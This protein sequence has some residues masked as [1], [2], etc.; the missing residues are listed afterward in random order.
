MTNVNINNK[1]DEI[2]Q[3]F[4]TGKMHQTVAISELQELGYTHKKAYV[5]VNKWKKELK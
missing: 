3:V 1:E 2:K 5:I 4:L